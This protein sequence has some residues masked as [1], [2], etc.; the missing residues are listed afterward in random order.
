MKSVFL[1]AMVLVCAC[2]LQG[3]IVGRVRRMANG[4]EQITIQNNGSKALIAFALSIKRLAPDFH[5]ER[6][7][8]SEPLVIFLDPLIDTTRAPLKAGEERP[9]GALGALR[10]PLGSFLNGTHFLEESILTAGIFE[11]GTTTGD[12]IL[13]GRL[14]VRRSNML[15]AVETAVAALSDAGSHNIPRRQVV[16]E[17][18]TLADS[19]NHWYLP[20][21][22]QVGHDLYE[23]I[24]GKLLNLPEPQLGE[25]FPPT[26]FVVQ[27][28]SS[29]NQQRVRL[30]G[31][32]P[33]LRE[34]AVFIG[35]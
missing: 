4:P 26:D 23:S 1:P 15:Q 19:L 16:E 10:V 6:D 34:A 14:I 27:Q 13:L 12:P 33:N 18:Q 32:E 31:S 8:P 24:V 20:W 35:R 28:M 9:V 25:P 30:L 17:F 3:Q 21:E 29:L 22:Q 2:A 7:S 5:P 11:D